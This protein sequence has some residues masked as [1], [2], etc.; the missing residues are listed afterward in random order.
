MGRMADSVKTSKGV[1]KSRERPHII[2]NIIRNLF[3]WQE[4]DV[5]TKLYYYGARYYNP[6]V[7]RFTQPDISITDIYNPPD[8]NR[9]SYVRNNPLIYVDTT[10]NTV[11]Y[12]GFIMTMG[13]PKIISAYGS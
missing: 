9:Y 1:P 12:A 11:V 4:W 10:G 8:L 13:V 7:R 3:T 2:Y 6:E 5:D